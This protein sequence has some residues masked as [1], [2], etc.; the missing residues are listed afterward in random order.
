M[1]NNYAKGRRFEYEVRSKLEKHGWFVV[2]QA[3]SAFPD[4]IAVF[5]GNVYA[6]ECKY[7]SALSRREREKLLEL[8]RRHGMLPVLAWRQKG[9]K[10]IQITYIIN[11]QTE[12]T[13][14]LSKLSK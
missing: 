10:S 6:I 1:A 11:T 2:R 12:P 13:N 3:K 4:L 7:N 5:K 9:R 8:H 14:Q